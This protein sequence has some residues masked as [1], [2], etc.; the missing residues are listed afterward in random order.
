MCQLLIFLIFL[1]SKKNFTCQTTIV[2]RVNA[3][4]TCQFVVVLFLFIQFSSD[5]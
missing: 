3:S 4:V 2:P 1:I 5:I